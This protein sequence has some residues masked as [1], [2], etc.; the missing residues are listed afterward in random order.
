MALTQTHP[1]STSR[2]FQSE[3]LDVLPGTVLLLLMS[4]AVIYAL[5]TSNWAAGLDLLVPMSLPA[6]LVGVVFARLRWLPSWLAHLLS[7]ALAL[8]WC[9]QLLGALL[10]ERLVSWRDWA[11]ELA[12]RVL[13]WGRVLASGGRGEDILLFVSALCLLS[14]ALVYGTAWMV[15]RNGWT[16]RAVVLNAVVALVNYTYVLP[17]PTTIFFVFLAAALLLL[18]YQNIR[19][20][21]ALW[22]AQQVEYPDLLPLRFLWSA[23]LVCGL[24]ITLTAVLPGSVSIDRATSTWEAISQP[25]K[26]AREQWEDMFSTINAPPGAGSGA[27][28]TRT[29]SFGGAR[30]LSNNIVMTVR[31]EKYDYWRAV[32]SDKYTGVDWQ[33]TTGEQARAAMGAG[34]A[35]QARTPLAPNELI[36]LGSTTGRQVV[37]Q[38]ITLATDRIDDLIMVGGT[39]RSINIPTTVEHNYLSENGQSSPNFEDTALIAAQERLSAGN[40]YTVTA[41]VSVVDVASLRN[42]GVDYPAWVRERYLQLPASVSERTRERAAQVIA[43]AG[44]RTPYDQAI[45]LQDYLRTFPYNESIPRPPDGSDAVDWFLFEQ[46]EGYCDY[47]ASSMVVMLRSQGVPARYVKGYAGGDFDVERGVYVVRESI[48]HSWPEV[49]FPGLGWERFEPTAASYTSAP[50]RPL[51]SV[52]GQD[53]SELDGAVSPIGG[54]NDPGRF[55]G[56]DPDLEQ[57]PVPLP[58]NTPLAAS[59]TRPLAISGAVLGLLALLL[60]AIY[61]RWRYELR[62]LSRARAAYAGMELLASWGG[63]SQESYR[64]PYEY[65][66]RLGAV[67][68]EHRQTIR[69]IAAAYQAERYHRAEAVA[70]PPATD[71][72]EL[73][74]A[75]ITRIFTGIAERLP[76]PR[77]RSR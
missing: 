52:L 70:L 66:E 20:R 63:L 26:L 3:L 59:W 32:A 46:R 30:Q 6:L 57:G 28:T 60:A 51:T 8:T 40:T 11:T 17:K 74:R 73:R 75:L 65:A 38:T 36:P 64:T 1:S 25:F 18:V 34:T 61:A 76:Q 9:V 16:W 54:P 21:Q 23:A 53:S 33:N 14:W 29:T 55:E 7:G 58:D 42:A 2:S 43:E 4:G 12:I 48:A 5:S 56:L 39:A 47:F 69:G 15:L 67:V 77:E 31:S 72:R 19:Q 24:L 49:Y 37:S 35:E 68:P 44:A 27:F 71:E 45:A 22:D 10:D 50:Q 62:G 13:I 41:L